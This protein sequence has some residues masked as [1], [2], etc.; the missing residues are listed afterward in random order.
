[1]A[2]SLTLMMDEW[3]LHHAS[4]AMALERRCTQYFCHLV[5]H[6]YKPVSTVRVLNCEAL[7]ADYMNHPGSAKLRHCCTH[8]MGLECVD[9][10]SAC[11]KTHDTPCFHQPQIG[12]SLS[13]GLLAGRCSCYE[14]GH[15]RRSFRRH[16]PSTWQLPSIFFQTGQL[17]LTYVHSPLESCNSEVIKEL[18]IV[19]TMQFVSCVTTALH[20][21]WCYMPL[22]GHLNDGLCAT[23]PSVWANKSQVSQYSSSI[24]YDSFFLSICVF[25]FLFNCSPNLLEGLVKY[26]NGFYVSS[27][28]S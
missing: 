19:S 25:I 26:Q 7:A 10:V 14:L 27:V 24:I 21:H 28:L 9:F 17:A 1:M 13:L 22:L 20:K 11:Q 16:V 2:E 4:A 15:C 6:C 3:C 5:S 18:K 8:S 23:M 12:A